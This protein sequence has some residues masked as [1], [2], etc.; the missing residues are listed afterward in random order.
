MYQPYVKLN[1][2]GASAEE[3]LL[4]DYL[5]QGP[6]FGLFPSLHYKHRIVFLS[7]LAAC[8]TFAFQ[9]L[10]SAI[11]QIRQ[12]PQ[13]DRQDVISTEQI[14][15]ASNINSLDGFSAAAGYIEAAAFHGLGDPPFVF[16]NWTTAEF[17]F[18][19]EKKLNETLTINTTA[20]STQPHCAN[21]IEDVVPVPIP[22][23]TSF[24]F[25]SLSIGR[26]TPTINVT[27]DA[28]AGNQQSGVVDVSCPDASQGIEK[29][30]VMFWFL[31]TRTDVNPPKREVK[32]VF[33]AP[34]IIP[35]TVTATAHLLDGRLDSC[36]KSGDFDH[37]NNVTGPPNNGEAFNALFF[38]TSSD[39]TFV[40]ERAKSIAAR[41]SNAI[42]HLAILEPGGI[43]QAFDRPNR[44]LDLTTKIYTQ[45]LSLSG[46]S[47]YFTKSQSTIPG[48]RTS[49][50][51]RLWI[52]PLPS[53]IL[54]ICLV[55]VGLSGLI[56]HI[57]NYRQRRRLLL[58]TPPGTI[59]SITA[60]TV[61]SGFGNLLLPYDNTKELDK[62]LK[63]IRF[64]LDK[65]TG[66]IVADEVEEG[67]P[68]IDLGRNEAFRVLLG[69]RED[70][71][72]Q[73][74]SS[75]QA[76]FQAAVGYPP[77]VT[78]TKRPSVY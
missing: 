53:R 69:H 67:I 19:T 28:A 17:I 60:L 76:A 75:S 73:H 4:L 47:I 13:T 64:R 25:S 52:D 40:Q 26:C 72:G 32:T 31:N 42:F 59:A 63:G 29:R 48:E 3:T 41:V 35:F 34:T 22:E 58:T 62:K 24:S 68:G 16:N 12:T 30:P 9:P 61:R 1:Q 7:G 66:A 71:F 56:V 54:S 70:P 49:I 45:H 77:W 20:V 21:S 10:A 74:G 46:K 8:L 5:Y 15:L 57:I 39:N 38:N 65:R 23:T 27:F 33:C 51:P 2:G 18:P 14:G 78:K 36:A 44:L 43:Q 11:G 37:D 55:L 6:F 50:V